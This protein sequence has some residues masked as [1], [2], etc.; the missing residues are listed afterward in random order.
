MQFRLG[1]QVYFLSWNDIFSWYPTLT[2]CRFSATPLLLKQ[3]FPGVS[4]IFNSCCVNP[5]CVLNFELKI[6]IVAE[7][8]VNCNGGFLQSLHAPVATN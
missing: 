4:V 2:E 6:V 7:E 1:C 3:S 5:N 8:T